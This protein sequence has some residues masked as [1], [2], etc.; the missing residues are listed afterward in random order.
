VRAFGVETH[1]LGDGAVR[2]ALS[3]DLD[4]STAP[5]AERAIDEAHDRSPRLMVLDLRGLEFM[6]STGLRVMVSA[7]KRARRAGRRAVI[8]QGPPAVR[9]VFE[10]TRLDERLEIV[11]TPEEVDWPD[12]RRFRDAPTHDGSTVRGLRC[13]LSARTTWPVWTEPPGPAAGAP[14]S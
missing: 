12:R 5:R 11:D 7:D 8:I 2:V 3:G 14:A 13:P 4:L 6:D 9:R 1:E 10:I